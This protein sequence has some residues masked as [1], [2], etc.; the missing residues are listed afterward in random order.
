MLSID[1]TWED[2]R[3]S[4]RNIAWARTFWRDMAAFS[5]GGTYLNF[6]GLGEEREELVR[7][8]YGANYDRLVAL[9]RK[10]DPANLFRLNQN[11]PPH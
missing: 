7:A 11:I 10:Y 9:K 5:P 8:A 4:E 1:T 6:P 2:P 3:D